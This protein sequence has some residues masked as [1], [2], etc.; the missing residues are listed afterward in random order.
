MSTE[1]FDEPTFGRNGVPKG[2]AGFPDIVTAAGNGVLSQAGR[3]ASVPTCSIACRDA[4]GASLLFSSHQN[5]CGEFASVFR[6]SLGSGGADRNRAMAAAIWAPGKA[7]PEE[8][9]TVAMAKMDT[10]DHLSETILNWL[11][12]H[13]TSKRRHRLRALACGGPIHCLSQFT[14]WI[15]LALRP[16]IVSKLS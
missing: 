13:D 9:W 15:W 16:K 10:A 1:L 14:K 7:R 11:I 12:T 2:S 4:T 3:S 5:F 8:L 6:L